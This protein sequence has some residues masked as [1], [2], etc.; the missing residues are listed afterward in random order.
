M[1]IKDW[2]PAQ[3]L[4]SKPSYPYAILVLNQ[5]I[6]A[7]ALDAVIEG[8]SLL[9]CADGGGD[10][11]RRYEK[12]QDLHQRKPDAIV[13]DLDSITKEA[14]E[15]YRN[16]GVTI[17]K[18]PDQYSTDFA[19]SLKWLRQVWNEREGEDAVLDVV[20]MGG[21]G[22]RVDQ[23]FSQIHHMYLASKNRDLLHGSMYLLS[24]QS[25]SF[26][27][28]DGHNKLHVDQ[29]AFTE[30][31]GVIP[32]LGK[33]KISLSGFEWDVSDWETELGGQ[34]STSNHIKSNLLE[35]W[36]DGPRALF[37]VE[38]AKKFISS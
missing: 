34:V 17:F 12:R 1:P 23:G 5:P 4:D 32:V 7:N 38:L 35:V 29:L 36:V 14:S 24:E 22:G 16:L 37:T 8:T 15:H 20:V 26:I 9:V 19:K 27:L 18:D 25:L 6:N 28:E 31:V 10:S 30:N 13:G 3:L 33:T 11:L 2:Y 21:L